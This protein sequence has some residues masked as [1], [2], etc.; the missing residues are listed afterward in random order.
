MDVSTIVNIILC[1]L[2]FI[3]AA[4]S[5]II[6]ILTLKQNSKMIESST[7]PQIVIYIDSITICEQQSYF[8]IKNFGQSSA[9]IIDFT[10][11]TLLETITQEIPLMQEQFSHV[12]GIVLASGQSC[13]LPY[14]VTSLPDEYLEFKIKYK[15]QTK[16]YFESFR[17]HPRKYIHIPKARPSTNTRD[18]DKRLVHTLR[19][20]L[21]RRL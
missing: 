2:S 1:V 14:M 20:M 13:M 12:K 8:I 15:S 19:E 11:P 16:T 5:V 10:Y 17:L 18:D 9:E 7:R 4:I 6:V 3:L 21:E